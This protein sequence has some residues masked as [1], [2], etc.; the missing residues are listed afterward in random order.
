[1]AN[2]GGGGGGGYSVQPCVQLKK[3]PFY[4][5]LAVLLKPCPL[6][7]SNS[8]RMQENNFFFQL[9]AGQATDLA[10][11]RD[12]RNLAKMEHLIQVQLRFCILDTTAPQE[13]YFPPNVLVKVNGKLCQLPV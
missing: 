4:D 2:H 5:N 10:M 6:V 11:N 13:D 7:P 12:M 1:M 9:T 3:L 8:Q